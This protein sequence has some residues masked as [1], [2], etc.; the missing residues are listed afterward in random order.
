MILGDWRPREAVWAQFKE[1][2]WISL[3]QEALEEPK[4]WAVLHTVIDMISGFA[5]I[6]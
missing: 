4:K 5:Y 3:R 6:Y 2:I 1:S